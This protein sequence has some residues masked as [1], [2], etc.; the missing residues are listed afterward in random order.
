MSQ[1]VNRLPP[2][3]LS[4]IA[5]DIPNDR[6]EDASSIVPLT[7][8]CRY[9]RESIIS[10]PENWTS[11]SSRS[12]RGLAAMSLKRAKSAPLEINLSTTLARGGPQFSD[13]LIPHIKN[14]KTLRVNHLSAIEL[15][16]I[17]PNFPRSMPNLRSFAL[18]GN[19]AGWDRSIDP[20]EPF[21]PTLRSL[22][23]L[24]IS[25]YPSLLEL[26]ALTELI[27]RD[28]RFNLR[29]DALLDF[30]EGNRS[31]ESVILTVRFEESSLHS[32]RRQVARK[33]DS[34]LGDNLL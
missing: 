10:N 3:I 29:L 23:L 9:W 28:H 24:N 13:L 27:I 26:K 1:P 2:E 14:T 33:P 34:T 30:L 19:G 32:S 7:H 25:L 15:K 16:D 4:Y 20:F 12:S 5:R 21:L 18:V 31:L 8:V 17:L 6:D 11:I 22:K